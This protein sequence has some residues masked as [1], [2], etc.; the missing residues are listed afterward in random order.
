MLFVLFWD[1]I[2]VTG[3]SPMS[4]NGKSQATKGAIGANRAGQKW[5]K[6]RHACGWSRLRRWIGRCASLY[7]RHTFQRE[8][9]PPSRD[10]RQ[11][12]ASSER[13]PRRYGPHAGSDAALGDRA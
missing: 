7:D 1:L 6:F 12:G 5:L 3:A 13:T 11:A 4:R 10:K 9:P 2:R 8:V